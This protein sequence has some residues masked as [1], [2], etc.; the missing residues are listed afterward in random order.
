MSQ[1][2]QGPPWKSKQSSA[3]STFETSDHYT[4]GKKSPL[5]YDLLS[6]LFLFLFFIFY[7]F[8]CHMLE[9]PYHQCQCLRQYLQDTGFSYGTKST[10][11]KK[12]S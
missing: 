5:E 2:F 4:Q 6:N 3:S 7:I 9:L 11:I 8:M 12:L 1:L 10:L